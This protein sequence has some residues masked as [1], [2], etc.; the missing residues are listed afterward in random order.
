PATGQV[1]ALVSNPSYDPNQFVQGITTQEFK[2]L[3]NSS[4]RPLFNRAL[5][6]QF[7]IASTIKPFMAIAGLD[8]G[9]ITPDF[10]IFDPGWFKLPN[11]SH[12]YHDWELKGHGRV[13]VIKAIAVSC[14]TFFF[15]LGAK[16]GIENFD[17]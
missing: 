10:M 7:P 16:M 11:S 13:D 8:Y 3:Q 6:G 5:R 1:L 4:S 14:D 12:I 17:K 9:F 2:D 15:G